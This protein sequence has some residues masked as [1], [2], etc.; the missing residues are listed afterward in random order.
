MAEGADIQ[1]DDDIIAE[2]AED[3]PTP[4]DEGDYWLLVSQS[5][6]L[7]HQNEWNMTYFDAPALKRSAR[8]IS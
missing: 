5:Y 8:G 3:T 6:L 7:M 4:T 1:P 2:H